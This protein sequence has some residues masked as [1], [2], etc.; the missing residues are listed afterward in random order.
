MIVFYIQ[1][2]IEISPQ[3]TSGSRN[4]YGKFKKEETGMKIKNVPRFTL[5]VSKP[6]LGVHTQLKHTF[7]FFLHNSF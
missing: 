2:L 4:H 1:K 3:A 6:G 7:Y 5:T